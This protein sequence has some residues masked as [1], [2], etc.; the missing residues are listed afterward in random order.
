MRLNFILLIFF[1]VGCS[2]V[3]Q[4]KPKGALS[5]SYPEPKYQINYSK[6]N[7]KYQ[8]NSFA[9]VK[10]VSRG[11]NIFYPE[12]KATLYL[13]YTQINNNL[14]SLLN[15]AYKLPTKHIRKAQE[16]PE[17]IFINKK[18][19]VYGTMFNVVGNAASQIQF[20]LTDSS[21]NFLIGSLYFY[22]KPNYDSLLPAVKYIERDI[23][24][25]VETLEWDYDS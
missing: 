25:L 17:R 20:F 5:L 14:D 7:Y 3:Q 8:Y 2:D 11:E 10:K 16:I 24:K 19:K 12:L 13:S 18:K 1:Y 9:Q 6:K 23:I 22:V 15:D 21:Y 4:P